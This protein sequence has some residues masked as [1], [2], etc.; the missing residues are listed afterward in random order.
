MDNGTTW[1]NWFLFICFV[2]LFFAS[3]RNLISSFLRMEGM[4]NLNITDTQRASNLSKNL[5]SIVLHK[6]G[7]SNRIFPQKFD[8]NLALERKPLTKVYVHSRLMAILF[9]V[10]DFSF[11]LI[12]LTFWKAFLVLFVNYNKNSLKA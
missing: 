2:L 3:L 10:R 5:S 7:A 4:V 12:V 9:L 11:H 1:L 6:T 8:G